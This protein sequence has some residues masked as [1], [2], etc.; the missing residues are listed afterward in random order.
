MPPCLCSQINTSNDGPL[1][2]DSTNNTTTSLINGPEAT[3]S[4]KSAQ[5]RPSAQSSK[6]KGKKLRPDL[7]NGL[8]DNSAAELVSQ[9][10]QA[11]KKRAKKV[12]EPREMLPE[13]LTRVQDPAGPD[14]PRFKH[15]SEEVA[16]AKQKEQEMCDKLMALEKAKIATLAELEEAQREAEEEENRTRVGKWK[17]T[18]DNIEE[19]LDGDESDSGKAQ[20]KPKRA[21]KAEKGDIRAAVDLAREK[22]AASKNSGSKKRDRSNTTATLQPA[23][24]KCSKSD[25]T[26]GLV[27]N[28]RAKSSIQTQDYSKDINIEPQDTIGGLNDEDAAADCPFFEESVGGPKRFMDNVRKNELVEIVDISD[29]SSD[30]EPAETPQPPNGAKQRL[31][32][33]KIAPTPTPKSSTA[34]SSLKKLAGLKISSGPNSHPIESIKSEGSDSWQFTSPVVA[35]PSAEIP[36]FARPG[37]ATAFLP[38]AYAKL[39]SSKNPFQAFSKGPHVIKELQALLDLIY[40]DS[41]HT[42]IWP[43]AMATRAINC[44]NETRSK[45]GSRAIKIVDKW[46]TNSKALHYQNPAEIARYTQWAV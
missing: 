40:V 12:A 23:D 30:G 13:R 22:L 17:D 31:G 38:T 5:K 25:V 4:A 37:W 19:D 35:S 1:E 36:P 7:Q 14:R 33:L 46:F 41:G 29:S 10:T 18:Q 15:S 8:V 34:T 32:H 2:N 28:W 26:S 21:K 16:A 3:P 42:L 6:A 43:E 20:N 27:T 39:G 11:T 24:A 45:F 9:K 44:L